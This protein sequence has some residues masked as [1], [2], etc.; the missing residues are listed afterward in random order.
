M[1]K[2]RLITRSDLPLGQ[3]AVQAA[4]ALREWSA[5]HPEED[6]HWYKT[7]NTLAMLVVRDEDSLDDLLERTVQY[8][9]PVAAFYEPDRGDEL[10]AIA[11]GPGEGARRLC[12]GLPLA[13]SGREQG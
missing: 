5:Q 9:L 7:S 13:M 10:T 11:L 8:G 6:Q 4:H 3:Q 2:L 1:N 12:R